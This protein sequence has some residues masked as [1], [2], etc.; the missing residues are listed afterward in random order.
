MIHVE[1]DKEIENTQSLLSC[2]LAEAATNNILLEVQPLVRLN[3]FG[4][5]RRQAGKQVNGVIMECRDRAR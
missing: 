3:S 4:D 1:I 5:M 2:P